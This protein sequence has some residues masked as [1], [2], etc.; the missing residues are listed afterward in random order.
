MLELLSVLVLLG[1]MCRNLS[2][3]AKSESVQRSYI[4]SCH[5]YIVVN[6]GWE[7]NSP[8]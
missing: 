1:E 7:P 3:K 5:Q 8:A 4:F 6:K 2:E